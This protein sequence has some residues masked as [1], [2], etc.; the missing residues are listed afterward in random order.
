M[1]IE[2]W[3]H[4][5]KSSILPLLGTYYLGDEL[6]FMHHLDHLVRFNKAWVY[7]DPKGLVLQA[8][9]QLG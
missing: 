7:K 3:A 8:S 9:A 4:D 1:S 6:L 2:P 5:S